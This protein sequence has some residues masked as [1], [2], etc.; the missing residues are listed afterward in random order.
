MLVICDKCKVV[1]RIGS[2]SKGKIYEESAF[3]FFTMH[4]GHP[5]RIIGDDGGWDL[6][7]GELKKKGYKLNL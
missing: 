3:N 4:K 7:I 2:F 5:I 1:Q 6:V